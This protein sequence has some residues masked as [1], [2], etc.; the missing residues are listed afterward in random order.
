M[1]PIADLLIEW[2]K[3]RPINKFDVGYIT[4]TGIGPK[5]WACAAPGWEIDIYYSA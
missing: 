5:S 3:G 1:S 4:P 2:H